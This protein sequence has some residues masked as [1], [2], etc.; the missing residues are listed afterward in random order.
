ML[1][2]VTSVPAQNQFCIQ[3]RVV[4]NS[5]G[6][7][8][9]FA[10]V[11]LSGKTKYVVYADK[12]GKFSVNVTRGERYLLK[13]SFVGYAPFV[14]NICLYADTMMTVRLKD[15]FRLKEVVITAKEKDTPVT[16]SVIGRQAMSQLQPNSIA[17]L[18]ELLP[19]G[20]SKDPNMGSA[21]TIT[22]R[23]TGTRNIYGQETQNNNYAISSLGTLF[24]IDG[25]PVSTDANMQ[26]S[27][28][29]ST[30]GGGSFSAEDNRNVTNRGV[31]MRSISTD[32]IEKVEV[33][34]GIPSVEYGN[35]TSGIVNIQKIRRAM[36]LT[37]R[38]KADGYSKLFS[39]G[40]GLA[41]NQ[42]GHA[43]L[44]VDLGY[45]DSKIDP[46]DNLENY[47]RVTA[48]ARFTLDGALKSL[49]WKWDS[50]ADYSGSFDNNKSD[51]DMNYGRI[52]E[53]KS[54]FN[55]FSFTN[56]LS[57]KKILF[58]FHEFDVNTSVSMQCDRL[59]EKRLV[60]PQRY[61]IVP[62]SWDEGE[63]V[64]QAVFA[65]YVADYLCDGKPFNAFV[66]AKG[67]FGLK[68]LRTPHSVKVGI[69]WD[70][71]KNF[72]DGQVY[73]MYHPLSLVGWSSR[74]RRY[75]DIPALQNLSAFAEDNAVTNVGGNVLEVMMGVRLNTLPKLDKRYDMSG[76]IYADPRL[77][78]RWKFPVFS[79]LSHPLKLSLSGGFGVTSKM[80][81]LNYLYPDKYYSNF[82]E[83]AYY[84]AVDPSANSM[85]VVKSYIQNP[86]NY[87]IRPARNHKWEIRLN[88]DWNDNSLTVDFFHENMTSGF[89]YSSVYGCYDYRSY[90]VSAM[91]PGIEYTTIP[92]AVKQVLN[93]Y[94][95][96]G[97]GSRLQKEGIELQ[98]SSRRIEPIRTGINISGAWFR[99][100][101]TNSQPMFES[102]SSVVNNTAISDKYIGL[103]AWNDGQIN[104]QLNT[105]FTLDTQ[106]S[107]WGL[108]FTT[109]VQCMWLVRTQLQRKD[110]TPVSYLSAEDG[111]L[112]EYTEADES[113]VYLK[114]LLKSYNE[115]MFKP[116]TVP[117]SM[118]VNL[119]VTKSIG[120]YMKVSF[121]ANKILDDL[122][123][124]KSN[125]YTIRRNVSPY[126]GVEANFTI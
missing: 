11:S 119:K 15:D 120:K 94:T 107:E 52:D 126:F 14:R 56:N 48:S 20:Y 102:V 84:D 12:D 46:T 7:A 85:F 92:Y 64:A 106:V 121:F 57:L 83:L 79:W 16:T 73:D 124:Y 60:A 35:L 30:Q 62:T 17:D 91:S 44:N 80:P 53:Y 50:S 36:P 37:I 110:G 69:D 105:N 109:S 22:L 27:P 76:K 99:S 82:T 1:L 111:Q 58:F 29:S 87:A 8:L 75:K 100:V 71:S 65:E 3:G 45:L 63:N 33:V 114:Q 25:A 18:M 51:P 108:I 72:G 95:K 122:P 68:V 115:D 98:F 9:P 24:L 28:L 41:L 61:G 59:K 32:D 112:H 19:G 66:K 10:S 21:N 101:Y 55:R 42:S 54:S 81:T 90:D 34:R 47:K 93:G 31:D 49:R 5:D 70:Y 117:F 78:I 26:Y 118:I 6:E 77:N 116:F 113:N 23:E 67:L 97:N 4:E 123:D 43:I 38:F 2:I 103:Y 88:A 86:T 13:V 40:K 104:Q 96:A 125:G 74:P 89:R 39:V